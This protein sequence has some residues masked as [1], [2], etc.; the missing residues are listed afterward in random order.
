ME[1]TTILELYPDTVDVCSIIQD[2]INVLKF[3]EHQNRNKVVLKELKFFIKAVEGSQVSLI[4]FI[5]FSN[6]SDLIYGWGGLGRGYTSNKSKWMD[7]K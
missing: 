1:T 5:V 3:E 2:Y 7:Q 6:D 4:R